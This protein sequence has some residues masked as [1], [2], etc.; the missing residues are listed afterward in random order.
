LWINFAGKKQRFLRLVILFAQINQMKFYYD[1]KFILLVGVVFEDEA[2]V[3]RA[4][5]E[6]WVFIEN[7]FVF[8]IEMFPMHQ[9]L[10]RRRLVVAADAQRSC[11]ARQ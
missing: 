7:S 5:S 11:R 4:L 10:S 1:L 8:R 2:K 3:G 6:N 9:V